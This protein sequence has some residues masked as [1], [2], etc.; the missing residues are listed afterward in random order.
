MCIFHGAYRKLR[1]N[2]DRPSG[3]QRKHC[4]YPHRIWESVL[5]VQ[6][7]SR[8]QS[9]MKCSKFS[10][11][12]SVLCSYVTTRIVTCIACFLYSVWITNIQSQ[13]KTRLLGSMMKTP[14]ATCNGSTLS[15]IWNLSKTILLTVLTPDIVNS[16]CNLLSLTGDFAIN[17]M[18]YNRCHKHDPQHLE[19]TG[20]VESTMFHGISRD[21]IAILNDVVLFRIFVYCVVGLS[22]TKTIR[23]HADATGD[24]Q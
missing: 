4:H 1:S 21:I 5:Q 10:E 3:G 9:N 14:N 23:N 2:L 18:A 20:A 19:F 11:L 12:S 22:Y 17:I 8:P 24:G 6:E 16:M 15:F 7:T 13:F